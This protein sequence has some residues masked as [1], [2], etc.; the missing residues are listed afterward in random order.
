MT[1]DDVPQARVE[2][3][4]AVGRAVLASFSLVAIVVDPTEPA[5]YERIAYALL[6]FYGGY[7]ILLAFFVHRAQV[8][9]PRLGIVTHSLDLAAFTLI[10][11][12]TE[13]AT[14]PFFIYFVFS[15]L[16]ATLRWQWRGV[17]W[18][19]LVATAAY[20][21]MGLFAASILRDHE[22]ELNRFI[23]RCADLVV[24]G[25]LLGYLGAYAKRRQGEMSKLAVWPRTALRE[26]GE[27]LGEVLQHAAGL[28]G[29]PRLVLAWEE[30]EEPWLHLASWSRGAFTW[31][32]ERPDAFAPLVAE[33]LAGSDFLCADVR[34]PL[35]TITRLGPAG[36]RSWHGRP[37]HPGLQARFAMGAVVSVVLRGEKLEG[38]LFGLDKSRLGPDD[39]VLGE[40]VGRQV[41]SSM[42][43]FYFVR[44][45]QQAAVVEE[46]VRLARDLHDGLL[47][48]L[49][50]TV[51]QL[52]ALR[53]ELPEESDTRERLLQI[54]L[55]MVAQQQELR[56][57]I[58]PLKSNELEPPVGTDEV[59]A[60][61]RE[62]SE[63]IERQWGQR[64]EL[65]ADD[66]RRPIPATMAR[67]IDHLV[68]EALGNAARHARASLH[69]VTARTGPRGVEITVAD[70]GR[71]FPFHGRYDLKALDTMNIGPA[72]L[73]HRVRSLGGDLVI[74]STPSGSRV[75]MVLPM[76]GPGE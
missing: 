67:Q 72:S 5:R 26:P 13:G 9:V 51:F 65:A 29:V 69:R 15:L 1:F 57:V 44:E 31:T 42:D 35:P 53:R 12:F 38:R 71:G 60:R 2:R 14:S 23:I 21:G 73:R 19:G 7:S 34:A 58:Q 4:I 11:Y 41:A 36:V 56:Q 17:L 75:E 22:F 43:Q 28:L 8:L 52:E 39:L 54:Q 49:A 59:I 3:P 45:L 66:W 20:G 63:R 62:L 24:M 27:A 6:T 64:V 10:Q 47:Q 68:N 46:R 33:A 48:T 18:T 40:V 25:A 32:R 76:P 55:L 30:R 74:D 16:C 50:G 70:N 37:L 61:L